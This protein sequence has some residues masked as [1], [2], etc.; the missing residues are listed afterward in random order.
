MAVFYDVSQL[1]TGDLEYE[2][3][4]LTIALAARRELIALGTIDDTVSGNRKYFMTD[5]VGE[6][7]RQRDSLLSACE[8]IVKKDKFG[9]PAYAHS[10]LDD[11]GDY[12]CP[13]CHA[14]LFSSGIIHETSDCPIALAEAAIAAA[15]ESKAS[16]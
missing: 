9:V 6:L 10:T 12:T 16:L 5:K 1:T 13:F 15:T 4:Q 14:L 11:D 2:I 8:A 3:R 7:T